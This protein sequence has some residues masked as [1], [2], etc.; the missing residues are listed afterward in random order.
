MVCD[1][2]MG[3]INRRF[4]CGRG[5]GSYNPPLQISSLQRNNLF[6]FQHRGS[7]TLPPRKKRK[8]HSRRT[9]INVLYFQLIKQ[10]IRYLVLVIREFLEHEYLKHPVW[11]YKMLKRLARF[12]VLAAF[13]VVPL[14]SLF[15]T[16]Q[17]TMASEHMYRVL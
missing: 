8:R 12:T 9:K 10:S 17:V 3:C 2:E 15:L 13:E 14:D 7:E 16:F 4:H 6:E 1:C 5:R 11:V